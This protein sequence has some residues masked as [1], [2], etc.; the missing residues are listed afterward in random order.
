MDTKQLKKLV[1]FARKNGVLR[2]KTAD[3]EVELSPQALFPQRQSHN[4][5]SAKPDLIPTDSYSADE[6]LFW[7]AGNGE[8]FSNE[9]K[10]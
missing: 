2:I 1:S 10:Q 6:V 8:D 3:F 4:K 7:S 9:E 5:A